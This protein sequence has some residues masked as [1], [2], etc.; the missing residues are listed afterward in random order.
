MQHEYYRVLAFEVL[1]LNDSCYMIVK[2]TQM[3]LFYQL[4]YVYSNPH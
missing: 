4:W 2:H 1:C 3:T